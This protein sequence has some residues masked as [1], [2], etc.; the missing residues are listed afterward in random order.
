V[1]TDLT[2]I[3][4]DVGLIPGLAQWIKDPWLGSGVAVTVANA[5]SYSSDLTPS[6]GTSTC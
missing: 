1:A 4:K 5:V 3:L 6:L 2:S